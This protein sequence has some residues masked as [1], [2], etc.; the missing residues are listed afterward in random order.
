MGVLSTVFNIQ[1]SCRDAL[2]VRA[3]ARCAWLCIGDYLYLRVTHESL[4]SDSR[5]TRKLRAILRDHLANA[6]NHL[7][8]T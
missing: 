7:S 8:N 6:Q 5:V 4:A 3:L 1:Y 2:S